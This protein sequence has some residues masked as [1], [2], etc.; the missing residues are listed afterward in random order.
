MDIDKLEAMW[1]EGDREGVFGA[2]LFDMGQREAVLATAELMFRLQDAFA[3]SG[4]FLL[5]LARYLTDVAMEGANRFM[6]NKESDD[7]CRVVVT[8]PDC[9][10]FR[11][12]GTVLR[13]PSH[14]S[15]LREV[16]V[17]GQTWIIHNCHL[18]HLAE[19]AVVNVGNETLT[20]HVVSDD[21]LV[22]HGT[23]EREDLG[24]PFVVLQGTIHFV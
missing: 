18:N 13:T 5:E 11:R 20:V 17:D 3:G 14:N 22:S 8:D 12:V 16:E 10:V 2:L 7:G 6:I 23:L 24:R 19:G 15:A 4:S 1:N 9:R 21:D